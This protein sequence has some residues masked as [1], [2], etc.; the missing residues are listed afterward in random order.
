VN[1]LPLPRTAAASCRFSIRIGIKARKRLAETQ[2]RAPRHAKEASVRPS[3]GNPN[4]FQIRRTRPADRDLINTDK[5]PV[6]NEP[7]KFA[8]INRKLLDARTDF[9]QSLCTPSCELNRAASVIKQ[10]ER[11]NRSAVSDIAGSASTVRDI[12]DID[13][14]AACNPSKFVASAS[15][16]VFVAR[17]ISSFLS[18]NARHG[19]K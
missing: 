15:A 16:R 4:G 6:I 11:A 5:C 14:R 9:P 13:N 10:S 8:L 2:C 12:R 1:S 7:R 17:E 19:A 18:Q 3:R